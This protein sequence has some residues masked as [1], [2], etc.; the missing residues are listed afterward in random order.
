MVFDVVGVCSAGCATNAGAGAHTVVIV[1]RCTILGI[2]IVAAW[3]VHELALA[4]IASACRVVCLVVVVVAAVVGDASVTDIE[5]VE[6]IATV[7]AGTVVVTARCLVIGV[8]VGV[9]VVAINLCWLYL[10][11]WV[12][13]AVSSAWDIGLFCHFAAIWFDF[14][15]GFCSGFGWI[16][17][18]D[19][20]WRRQ[21]WREFIILRQGHAWLR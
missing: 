12:R 11:N 16:E 19:G 8:V 3:I 17:R 2:E 1:A 7:V 5:D 4:A 20:G 15:F 18:C 14:G 13:V 10:H 9:V 6:C 21:S